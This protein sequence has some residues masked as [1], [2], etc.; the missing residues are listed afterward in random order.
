MPTDLRVFCDWTWAETYSTVKNRVGWE[1]IHYNRYGNGCQ[2][3]IRKQ[4]ITFS[5]LKGHNF[6]VKE[7]VVQKFIEQ[8][9][10]DET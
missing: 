1:E 2:S 10:H 7:K 6:M 3:L 9:F 4:I 8:F 5:F